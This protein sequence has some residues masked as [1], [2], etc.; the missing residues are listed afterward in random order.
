MG[1]PS[2]SIV[3]KGRV[4][5]TSVYGAQAG[6]SSDIRALRSEMTVNFRVGS[7]ADITASARHVRF[8]RWSQPVDA[9]L[10]LNLSAGVSI[11][12]ALLGR[13]LSRRTAL[14]R[15]AFEDTDNRLSSEITEYTP[16]FRLGQ[17]VAST[18]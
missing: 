1:A 6:W 9:T 8:T 4:T 13:S 3:R 16:S 5:C 11:P 7:I 15:W 12:K 18:G 14:F 17:S 2:N 10:A